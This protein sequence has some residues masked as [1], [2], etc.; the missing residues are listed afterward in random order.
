MHQILKLS[1]TFIAT[2]ILTGI[3]M[4]NIVAAAEEAPPE[5]FLCYV[6]TYTGGDSKGISRF[7]LDRSTGNVS[8]PEV[9][10]GVVNPSFLA[11]HPTQRYLYAVSEIEDMNGK[12]TGGV[13]AFAIDPKTGA[14][15]ALNQQPSEGA[16]P[17][18]LVVDNA[19]KNVLVAN[20]GGGSVAVI[21]IKE[22]GSL[23][24]PSCSIQHEGSSVNKSRQEKPHA[25]SIN[26]DR[27]N[28][29][30]FVAD[31]GL[32]KVMIYRFDANKGTLEPNDPPFVKIHP[33]AGPRHFAFHPE[34]EFA[35]VINEI[36]CTV[37]A[38]KYDPRNGELTPIQTISTLPPGTPMQDSYSTAEVVVHP[39]GKLLFGSNRGHDSIARYTID[40]ATGKLAF[41][42]TTP[43]QGKTPRNFAVD[44]TGTILL[45]ENQETGTIVLFR[46]DAATGNL[47]PTGT[48]L[49]IPRPV[50][51]RMIPWQSEK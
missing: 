18:H 43:T 12:K 36:D 39:S 10:T 16:G 46:I 49:K 32:D 7:I 34:G 25:H 24:E 33:G 44:P 21:P 4:A 3:V 19:G 29:F 28:N 23:E 20:Y 41:L 51:I 31:L 6:G 38:M 22:D 14:L 42:G 27:D 15:K 13:T 17:C 37:T 9:T 1:S 2:F 30:A 40:P 35:Y 48:S 47:T 50:C 11:I 8:A 26:L 5:T 45:A